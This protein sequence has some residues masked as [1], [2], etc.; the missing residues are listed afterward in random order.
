MIRG[1]SEQVPDLSIGI[2]W[3][4]CATK[5]KRG[6]MDPRFFFCPRVKPGFISGYIL[7]SMFH[8]LVVGSEYFDKSM[9]ND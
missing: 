5:E 1:E 8:D 7:S 3:G 4:E 6:S 9:A 2:L